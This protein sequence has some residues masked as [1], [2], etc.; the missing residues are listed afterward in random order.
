MVG[1]RFALCALILATEI[2]S[3]AGFAPG[4]GLAPAVTRVGAFAAPQGGMHRGACLSSVL[5]LRTRVSGTG[6]AVRTTRLGPKMCALDTGILAAVGAVLPRVWLTTLGTVSADQLSQFFFVAS[7]IGYLIAGVA[8]LLH[9]KRDKWLL[10]L[11][12]TLT[13]LVSSTFHAHQCM[14]PAA[15]NAVHA[16]CWI[17]IAFAFSTG[18]IYI[19]ACGAGVLSRGTTTRSQ[20]AGWI[21]AFALF[22]VGGAHY[23][24]GHAL[25]HLVTAWLAYEVSLFRHGAAHVESLIP[26]MPEE[27]LLEGVLKP[28]VAGVYASSETTWGLVKEKFLPAP[29][30][31]GPS[32]GATPEGEQTR[33]GSVVRALATKMGA[34]RPG[35]SGD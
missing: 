20:L 15:S 31:A 25:W 6:P 12:V 16:L 30:G 34:K 35:E 29:A 26:A 28:A 3:S 7:N 4:G 33:A 14:L 27:G 8:I 23:T 10:G 1:G 17:D 5:K 19:A 18:G 13:G 32:K 24:T 9:T 2:M 22:S 11:S 21:L